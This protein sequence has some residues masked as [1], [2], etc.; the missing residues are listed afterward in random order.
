MESIEGII[1]KYAKSVDEA[2]TKLASEIWSQTGDVSFIHPGGHE[3]GWEEIKKNIYEKAMRD[4]FFERNLEVNNVSMHIYRDAAWAEFHWVFLA[5]F[6][7]NGSPLRTEGRETQVYRKTDRGW[8][9]VH[10]HY[11]GMPVTPEGNG[12]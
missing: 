3:H 9:L 4:T 11:S 7:S 6:R 5:K 10:V 12:F 1:R 2:D 8:F